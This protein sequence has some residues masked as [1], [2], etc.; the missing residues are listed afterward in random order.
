MSGN[1]TNLLTSD[2][3]LGSKE[4]GWEVIG[5]ASAKGKYVCQNPYKSISIQK[6]VVSTYDEQMA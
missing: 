5:K 3:V 1:R 4:V 6:S 2:S